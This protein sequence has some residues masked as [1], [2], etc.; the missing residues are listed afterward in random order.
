MC[1]LKGR[2]S[3]LEEKGDGRQQQTRKETI[4]IH[5]IPEEGFN[6]NCY[7]I[8]IG[9]FQHHLGLN[10]VKKDFSVCH[11]QTIPSEKKKYGK[12]YIPVM[13]CQLVNRFVARDVVERFKRLKTLQIYMGS[14]SRFART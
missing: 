11:R 13:Y 12:A 2:A 7:N 9:V 8:A 10:L 3:D 4:E 1:E 14:P 5:G 6:E